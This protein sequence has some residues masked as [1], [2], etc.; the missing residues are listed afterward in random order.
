M[1]KMDEMNRNIRLRSEELGFKAAVF[2]LAVWVLIECWR[3]FTGGDIF[4]P[5]PMIILAA[6]LCVQ[7]FSEM[8]MRRKM[9][10]GDEEYREPNKFLWGMISAIVIIAIVLSIGFYFI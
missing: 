7:G 4:N 9:I 1:K 6:V 8:F 3:N 10:S 5:I 2:V